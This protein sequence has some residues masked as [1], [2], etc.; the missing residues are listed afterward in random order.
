MIPE[1]TGISQEEISVSSRELVTRLLASQL[2]HI[3]VPMYQPFVFFMFTDPKTR[4]K[5]IKATEGSS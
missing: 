5:S 3:T 4:V 1:I 2:R